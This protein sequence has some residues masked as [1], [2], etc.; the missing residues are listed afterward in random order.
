M[1]LKSPILKAM[2]FVRAQADG[3][4]QRHIRGQYRSGPVREL[5]ADHFTD[6]MIEVPET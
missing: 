1:K 6:R 4:T 5:P 2:T 3:F